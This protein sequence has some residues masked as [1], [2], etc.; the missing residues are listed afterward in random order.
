MN[1]ILA[2]ELFSFCS[3]DHPFL[4]LITQLL[5]SVRVSWYL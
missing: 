2:E 1:L 5:S 4:Y 3:Y